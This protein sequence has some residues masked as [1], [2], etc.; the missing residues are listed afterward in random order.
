LQAYCL[1]IPGNWDRCVVAVNNQ[2]FVP[3]VVHGIVSLSF[4]RCFMARTQSTTIGGVDG[5]LSRA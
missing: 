3:H 5:G 1:A 4:A 2:G